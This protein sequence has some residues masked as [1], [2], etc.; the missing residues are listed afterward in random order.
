MGLFD[1]FKKQDKPA[2]QPEP[3]VPAASEAGLLDFHP[4]DTGLAEA[5]R[6]LEADLRT[7]NTNRRRP[8]GR[9]EFIALL[10]G[11]LRRAA[12]PAR[13]RKSVV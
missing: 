2:A 5:V 6:A 13:D 9:D 11:V 7:L 1:R 10:P 12:I 3:E 8:C 4:Y